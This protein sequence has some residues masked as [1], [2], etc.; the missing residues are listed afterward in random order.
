MPDSDSIVSAIRAATDEV[1]QMMLGVT[2]EVAP[3]DPAR[4]AQ[5][6]VVSLIGLTGTWAG[7]GTISCSPA[8]ANLV[9]RRMLM[10]ESE[11]A[12][13]VDEDTLDA[14]AELT[15]MVIGNVKHLLADE[16][17]DMAISIPTVV[18]GRNFRFKKLSGVTQGCVYFRF[19][20][21][22][23]EIKVALAQNFGGAPGHRDRLAVPL[24]AC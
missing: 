17:G 14:V 12:D 18:Y 19:E 15:N 1:F 3:E 9:A 4:E 13:S 20:D 2:L 16:F 7:S 21:S 24:L 8:A 10:L 22:Y 6:G 11:A 23:F 5:P